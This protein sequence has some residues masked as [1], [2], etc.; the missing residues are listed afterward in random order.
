[1]IELPLDRLLQIAEADRQKNEEA[2][3]ATAKAIDP[4]KTP[5]EVLASLQNDHPAAGALLAATQSDLDSL[6]QFITDRHI[7]TIP[8]SILRARRK[9]RRSCAP[10]RRHRWIRRGPFET[11]RRWLL[12]DAAQPRAGR[13]PSRPT[14]C[15]SGTTPPSPTCPCT[16]VYLGTTTCN[17]YA[18]S[19]PSDVRRVFGART[20]S[21]GWAHYCEQ[22][23]LDEGF[24]ANEPTYRLAQLQDALLRDIR[25]I[26]GI[27]LH[28][29]SMT[30][31]DATKL[32]ET[33]GHQPHPVSI[34]E[35]KRGTADA[36][37]GYYS[38]GKL[39]ILKLREDYKQKMGSAYTLQQFHDTFIGLGP[40]PLSLIRKA[41][42]GSAGELF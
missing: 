10:R 25:F 23:M 22:M 6:R 4:K 15:G 3:R 21:E 28:T 29:Q 1:M 8:V 9:R 37:Y 13:P 7:L 14:S 18:K 36:L 39:A 38:M 31:T 35:V 20:N 34:S 11:A 19:Y 32:F 12:H 24:H 42:L 17:S 40:L 33:Q 16:V 30:V 41:M 2:F 26:V 27:K 5:D